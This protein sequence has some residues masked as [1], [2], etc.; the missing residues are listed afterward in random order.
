VFQL[1]L[2][3]RIKTA[4]LPIGIPQARLWDSASSHYCMKLGLSLPYTTYLALNKFPTFATSI[5]DEEITEE[6]G[7]EDEAE[8]VEVAPECNVQWRVRFSVHHESCAGVGARAPAHLHMC[9][10]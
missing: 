8:V 5:I 9:W 10:Q 6:A 3:A 4:Q 1:W 7:A 2:A